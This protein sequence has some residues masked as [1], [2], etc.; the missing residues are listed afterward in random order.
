MQNE[1]ADALRH[2]IVARI[3]IDCPQCRTTSYETNAP[4]VARSHACP[5]CGYRLIRMS[6]PRTGEAER[7][8]E[9]AVI[10]PITREEW[11]A[12][13]EATAAQIQQDADDARHEREERQDWRLFGIMCG[14]VCILILL[15]IIAGGLD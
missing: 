1:L 4:G 5:L 15:A 6:D 8:R 13:C 2:P 10:V 3:R 11:Q 9:Q 12:A 7:F 14:C